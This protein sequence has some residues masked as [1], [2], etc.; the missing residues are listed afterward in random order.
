VTESGVNRVLESDAILVTL[1]R[2]RELVGVLLKR[3][4][5]ARYRGAALGYA[6]TLLSPLLLMAVYTVVFSLYLRVPL[7]NYP[8]FLFSAFIPWTWFASSLQ[9]GTQAL[10][11]GANLI[12]RSRLDA[13]I[14]PSVTVLNGLVHCAFSLP[15]VVAFALLVGRPLG[16]SLAALPILLGLQL[17]LTLGPTILLATWNVYLRDI[18]QIIPPLMQ[19]M[20]FA[21]PILYPTA[22][23]PERLRL[24]LYLNPW[25]YL[26]RGY[27][28]VLYEGRL[29]AV[30]DLVVLAA[31]A[32][33]VH[34]ACES[35]FRGY[36]HRLAEEL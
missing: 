15:L 16:S 28:R 21:S 14:L 4:T 5:L 6:W 34:L 9:E 23:V 1:W 7:E 11:S 22:V 27:Q 29:P 31:L 12:A 33:I 26:A 10:L 19:V 35:A 8:A 3:A 32:V 20:F 17:I 24:L 13:E 36:R 30:S 25:T 2:R 18:Q